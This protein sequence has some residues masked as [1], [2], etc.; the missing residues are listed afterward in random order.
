M[1]KVLEIN[2]Y[3]F[4]FYSNENQEPAHIHITKGTSNAKYWL[5]PELVEEYAYGFK[6][7]E[8]RKIKNI[9]QQHYIL[10]IEKWHEHFK[11]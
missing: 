6:I 8:R 5:E 10:L 4:S 1:P 7:I 2:G 11:S 9:L 3:K